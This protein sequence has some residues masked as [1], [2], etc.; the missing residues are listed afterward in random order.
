MKRLVIFLTILAGLV[1]AGCPQQAPPNR[2]VYLLLDTSGTYT[3]ELDKAQRIISFILARLNPGDS[4]AVARIDTGSFSEKD[5]IARTSFEDRP[6]VANQQKRRFRDKVGK[7]IDNVEPAKHTDI[8]GGVLQATEWLNE[9]DPGQKVVLVF[10]DMK[11][12]LPENYVRD[13]PFE[14]S[15]VEVVALNVTKLRSDIVDPRKYLG[16]LEQWQKRVEQAGGQWRVIN[17]LDHMTGL[18]SG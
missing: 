18:F 10:S 9:V 6:S 2:G 3:K 17:D 5:I 8:S 12:D 4:F 13:V 1:L 16:R 11:E 14:L 7:F 15:G